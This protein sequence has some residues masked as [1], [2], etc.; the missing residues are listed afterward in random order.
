[1]NLQK[2]YTRANF[3][4]LMFVPIPPFAIC[5]L[6]IIKSIIRLDKVYSVQVS[7]SVTECLSA[8]VTLLHK[9][10]CS[11]LHVRHC[12]LKVD[13]LGGRNAGVNS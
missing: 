3:H 11:A 1:M 4:D 10:L 8:P 5:H 6:H 7:Q 12:T 2:G 9:W 13:Q